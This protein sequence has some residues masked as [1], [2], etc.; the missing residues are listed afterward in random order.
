VELNLTPKFSVKQSNSD[1]RVS[2]IIRRYV[3]NPF[4]ELYLCTV[5][6]EFEPD[7]A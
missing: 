4:I 7:D 2:S 1:A 6:Y 3:C 5:A